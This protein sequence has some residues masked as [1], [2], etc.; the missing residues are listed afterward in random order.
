MTSRRLT[1]KQQL[2]VAAYVGEAKGNATEAARIAGYGGSDA[3]LRQTGSENLTKPHIIAA[4]E[5]LAE[6]LEDELDP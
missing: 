4:V 6:E 3:T 1:R 5:E 2:F